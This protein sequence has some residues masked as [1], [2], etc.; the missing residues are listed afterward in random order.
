MR[1]TRPATKGAQRPRPATTETSLGGARKI[2][3]R[4][5]AR[6]AACTGVY[7]NRLGSAQPLPSRAIAVSHA[8]GDSDDSR[9]TRDRGRALREARAPRRARARPPRGWRCCARR[10]LARQGATKRRSATQRG[11]AERTGSSGA[12]ILNLLRK[13]ENLVPSRK[14]KRRGVPSR[15]EKRRGQKPARDLG[16]VGCGLAHRGAKAPLL[17]DPSGG[18][19]RGRR[20][21]VQRWQV[22][23]EVHDDR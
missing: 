2:S 14:E 10:A 22:R 19:Q 1:K 23:V 20:R 12:R 5:A 15:K 11:V 9:G 3:E 21:P 8:D 4:G 13:Q 7:R 17:P 6:R 16:G 18:R